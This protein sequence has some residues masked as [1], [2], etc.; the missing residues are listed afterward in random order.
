MYT[1]KT[2]ESV[3][4]RE[5]QSSAES[6]HHYLAFISLF[7]KYEGEPSYVEQLTQAEFSTHAI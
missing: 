4:L 2:G 5:N 1:S 6:P 7:L 3:F